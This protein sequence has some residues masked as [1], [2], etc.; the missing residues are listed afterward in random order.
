MSQLSDATQSRELLALDGFASDWLAELPDE[1]VLSLGTQ[2]LLGQVEL[3][4]PRFPPAEDSQT[5]EAAVQPSAEETPRFVAAVAVAE[6]SAADEVE[7]SDGEHFLVEIESIYAGMSDAERAVCEER[8]FAILPKTLKSAVN[9]NINIKKTLAEMYGTGSMRDWQAPKYSH[10]YRQTVEATVLQAARICQ[11]NDT[12][13]LVKWVAAQP[14]VPKSPFVFLAAAKEL[15]QGPD[16]PLDASM[17]DLR[18]LAQSHLARCGYIKL[19]FKPAI[20]ML[21][22]FGED[23][24]GVHRY[25]AV[26]NCLE[27]SRD[28]IID[29]ERD[30]LLLEK[31]GELKIILDPA[32]V[33]LK[34]ARLI[35]SGSD[36]VSPKWQ[37][38]MDC[39]EIDPDALFVAGAAQHRVK[40]E[41]CGK[42]RVVAECLADALVRRDQW[43]VA[44]RM[45]DRE[46]RGIRLKVM[47]GRPRLWARLMIEAAARA[48]E[49]IAS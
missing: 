42:C 15:W 25:K 40:Q 33:N 8:M 35:L 14:T 18:A 12:L 27:L 28:E 38:R 6:S 41:V 22:G 43:G 9:A 17:A 5:G 7:T 26:A 34:L 13:A 10:P 1:A 2:L 32:G 23:D 46:R 49:A 20:A 45:S 4:G 24:G 11:T 29:C 47:A 39:N 44:G 21:Y 48:E 36:R 37:L 3:D 16:V 30:T 19:K 31:G